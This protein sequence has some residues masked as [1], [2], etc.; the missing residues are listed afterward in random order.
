MYIFNS[1][2]DIRLNKPTETI[3]SISCDR[4]SRSENRPYASTTSHRFRLKVYTGIMYELTVKFGL[5]TKENKSIIMY[6]RK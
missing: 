1:H 6:E 4:R 3:I 2:Q 5:K